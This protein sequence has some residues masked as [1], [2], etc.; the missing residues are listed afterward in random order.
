MRANRDFTW[1]WTGQAASELGSSMSLLVFPLL[2]YS[3]SGSTRVAGLATTGVLV[4][5]LVAS[6]P[7]G[8]VV[9][10]T[11]RRTV[12]V[13]AN[14]VGAATFAVL[15]AL[16]LTGTLTIASMVVLGV[17]AGVVSALAKPAGAAA[18]RAVVPPRDLPGALAASQARHHA[19]DLAGPPLGGALVTLARPLPFLVDAL[20]YVVAAL[21]VT[22]VRDPLAAPPV[23]GPPTSLRRSLGEGLLFL[24][25]SPV[26]RAMMAWASAN[27]LAANYLSVLITLRLAQAGV[28]PAAIGSVSTISAV[29]GLVGAALAPGIVRRVPTGAMTVVTGVVSGVALLGT[30]FTTD[31][32]LIGAC[33]ACSSLLFPATNAGI[34][35]YSSAVVPQGMQGRMHA[36]SGLV[37]NG[38]TPLAPLLAGVLLA[39]AGGLWA[40]VVGALVLGLAVTP[41]VLTRETRRLG[42]PSTWE[43]D[44]EPQS[45]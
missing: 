1:L 5:S 36:A 35:G 39:D 37:A 23:A 10:R 44:R 32:V 38:F 4:G 34:G 15:A 3:L 29:A 25:R 43:V 13:A 11:S 22:R 17:V 26:M 2:G 41:I 12:L 30:A 27:N 42:R 18:V 9:D 8:V 14:L 21:T 24:W 16:A 28:S 19:A 20:S 7:A 6:L 40:T 31:V 45:A 33:Y